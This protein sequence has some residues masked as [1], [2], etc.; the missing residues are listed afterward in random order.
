MLGKHGASG[1]LLKLPTPS[2]SILNS[3]SQNS[4]GT[5]QSKNLIGFIVFVSQLSEKHRKVHRVAG[6]T[7][8]TIMEDCELGCIFRSAM[9]RYSGT[10]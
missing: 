9:W 7:S 2:D 5:L 1:L 10:R 8:L 4:S 3:Q 6:S